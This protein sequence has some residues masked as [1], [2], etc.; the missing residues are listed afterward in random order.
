MEL[1]VPGIDTVID[2]PSR[3]P[4][5]VTRVI[6]LATLLAIG[7][8]ALM[9]VCDCVAE[10][11]R[12]APWWI[13]IVVAVGFGLAER[14]V[15]HI[16]YRREA[17][18][19]SMSEVPTAFALVFLSPVVAVGVRVVV[20][21][22]VIAVT[23]RPAA[24]K[25]VF[26]GAL[27]AF[28]TALAFTLV[29]TVVS[30]ESV[31]DGWL[32]VAIA[33]GAVVATL[34]GSIVVSMAIA[35]FEGRFLERFVSELRTNVVTAPVGAAVAAVAVAP[36]MLRIELAALSAVPVAA[37]WFVL[38]RHG[39]LDQRHRDLEALHGFTAVVAQSI[40]LADVARTSLDEALRL[41]R[42]TRGLL[43]V[44][45]E[46]G[47]LVID[48]AVG[49]PRIVGPTGRSDQRWSHV[50]E[51]DQAM[52]VD[53]GRGVVVASRHVGPSTG[54]AVPVR[55]RGEVIGLLVIADRTG[56][57]E[58][59]GGDDL[60]RATTLADQLA[61]G[62]RNALLHAGMERAA[63]SDPLTGDLNRTAFD[64]AVADEIRHLHPGEVGAVLML[65]LDRFKDINDTLGHF[66]GDRALVEFA[67]R[68]ARP[69]PPGR[70]ARSLRR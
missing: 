18:T 53:A 14:F 24:Y 12:P 39:R 60:A 50:I 8:G 64:R 31:D 20:S 33:G 25:L 13:A 29:R 4:N 9:L 10:A 11:A 68:V 43:Q 32:L 67:R 61:V 49:M 15:F 17:I 34:A 3:T 62:L 36:A 46:V 65:D 57:V 22:I 7:A 27:F 45:D 48:H 59:F 38:L 30:P 41:F 1:D 28:E 23:S 37:V 2:E 69:A 51:G 21:L 55:D 5:S 54:V 66:V 26:N 40:D 70:R 16:E 63:M 52:F 19:F 58:A 6:G 56:V 35:A 47:R 42:G 44:Y